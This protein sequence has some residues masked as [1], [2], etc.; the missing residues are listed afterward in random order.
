MIKGKKFPLYIE[1]YL[2]TEKGSYQEKI[3]LSNPD[4]KAKLPDIINNFVL[5]KD[6][7]VEKVKI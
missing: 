5:P 2:G 1:T 6:V 7:I 3:I 4:L